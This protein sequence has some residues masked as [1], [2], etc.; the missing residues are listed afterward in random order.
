[1]GAYRRP[2]ISMVLGTS[3]SSQLTLRTVALV[4]ESLMKAVNACE[5]SARDMLRTNSLEHAKPMC[6][7]SRQNAKTVQTRKQLQPLEEMNSH[8]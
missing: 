4:R 1:M 2:C 7:Q 5:M 3:P 6:M 8:A